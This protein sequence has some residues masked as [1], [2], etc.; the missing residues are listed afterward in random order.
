MGF[1]TKRQRVLIGLIHE[2]RQK[3]MSSNIAVVKGLFILKEEER[4]DDMIKF[5]SFLPYKYGPFSYD[6]YRDL[7][8]LMAEGY[9]TRDEKA[10][11]QKGMEIVGEMDQ[12]TSQK[13]KNTASKF[14]SPTHIKNYVYKHY[15]YYTIKSELVP[16]EEKK[17]KFGIFT[18]GYEGHNIDSFLNILIQNEIDILIDVRKNPFSMNFSFSQKKLSDYLDKVEIKYRHIPELGIKGELRK[19]LNSEKDYKELFVMYENTTV[20]EHS[21]EIREIIELG[22]TNRIA[23]MC[24]EKEL[25][26]CHRSV[27]SQH[28]E[29]EGIGVTHI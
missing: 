3:N 26:H 10:A 18:I 27:L 14:Q 25:H 21:K 23:L 16:H 5:Y 20:K 6:C 4:M 15:P 2:F 13:I 8:T 7:N 28:I 9:I 11:T 22:K 29:T 24:F 17:A 19:N 12:K 1:L